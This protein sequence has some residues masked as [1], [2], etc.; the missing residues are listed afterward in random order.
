MSLRGLSA[1]L[2]LLFVTALSGTAL[3]H[4]GAGAQV[5]AL[6]ADAAGQPGTIVCK[7][8]RTGATTQS[9][10]VGKTVVGAGATGGTF[11]RRGDAV[12]VTN[13][14]AGALLF[15]EIGGR[16][17]HPVTLRTGGEDSLSG[18]VGARGAYVLTPTRLL[19]FPRGR[20]AV[21]SSANLLVGDGSAAQVTL[22]GG[23]AYV[24]EKSG[25][26]EAFALRWDGNLE[27]SVAP[28]ADIPAGT[29]VGITGVDDLIVSPVAHLTTDANQSTVPVSNGLTEVQ[30]VATKEVAACWAASDDDEV[31]IT[32]PGSMTISCGHFGPGGFETY[33]SAAASPTGES[34]LDLDMRH[35]L[36]GI[37]GMHGGAPVMMVYERFGEH[38]DFMSSVGEIAVG[39]TAATGALLLP[40]LS[41]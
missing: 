33:T 41:R 10:A 2:L 22:A 35:G 34:V 15:E 3:A 21:A 1:I 11:S 5:C 31:C 28:V 36:V 23:H 37:L 16:L 9:V 30:E 20:T 19:Y 18:A 8:V 25:S 7:N 26:L 39:T 32:N 13:I 24:S 6:G 27:G 38:S 14:A 12:L 4:P 29:I 40:P 17:V